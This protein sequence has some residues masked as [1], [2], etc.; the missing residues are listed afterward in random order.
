MIDRRLLLSGA[1]ATGALAAL[2]FDA[3]ALAAEGLKFG[4]ATPF[5]FDRL[6]GRA[7]DLAKAGYAPPPRPAPDVLEAIDYDVHGKIRFRPELS[8]WADGPSPYPVT[9]FHLGRFFQRPVRMHVAEGGSA[10]EILYDS[11]CFDMPADSPARRLPDNS[12][13]AGFRLQ[14]RRGRRARLAPQRL[15]GVP[16]RLLLPRHRR[17]PPI[18]PVGARRRRRHGRVR[19]EPRNSRISRTS[20]SRPR[21]RARTRSRCARFSTGR[22]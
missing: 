22:A 8:L 20:S 14:E 17:A 19:A 3:A 9:F 21:R 16:R 5:S 2:R 18:R 15:G 11:A 12:G 7:R 4:P 6:K 10:R 13:F 1:A